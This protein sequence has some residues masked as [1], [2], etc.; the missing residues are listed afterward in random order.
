MLCTLIRYIQL[1]IHTIT[2]A[3]ISDTPAPASTESVPAPPRMIS[4]TPAAA[5]AS[6]SHTR[7]AV[8]KKRVAPVGGRSSAIASDVSGHGLV[9]SWRGRGISCRAVSSENHRFDPTISRRTLLRT[10]AG[11]GAGALVSRGLP[12]WAKPAVEAATHI[13]KP[14]SRPFPHLPAGHESMPEIKHVVMLM[15]ENHSFDNLLGMV[16]YQVPGRQAS[17]V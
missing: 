7:V 4:T 10:A 6:G 16:P 8:R 14:D 15:M 9:T 12:A 11:A 13:R 17:T 1:I 3:R 2:P 5:I